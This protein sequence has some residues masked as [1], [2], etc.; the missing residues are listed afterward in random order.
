[1]LLHDPLEV[2]DQLRVATERELCLDHLLV[3]GQA[4]VLEARDL[5]LGERLVREVGQR[6]TAP[7][8]ESLLQ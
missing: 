2:A 7:Q 1:M 4:Q 6:R 5:R 3:S 8:R